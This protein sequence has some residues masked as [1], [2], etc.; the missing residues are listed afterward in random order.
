MNHSLVVCHFNFQ[1]CKCVNAYASLGF[2]PATFWLSLKISP[3]LFEIQ[4]LF[5]LSICN[6]SKKNVNVTFLYI[7][8]IFSVFMHAFYIFSTSVPV[9][10]SLLSLSTPLPC[11]LPPSRPTLRFFRA[12]CFLYLPSQGPGTSDAQAA[13]IAVPCTR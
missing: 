3:S 8:N 7:F 5:T 1:C 10:P 6:L 9:S 13:Q 11:C 12:C 2:E 4:L